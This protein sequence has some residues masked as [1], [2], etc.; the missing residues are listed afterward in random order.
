MYSKKHFKIILTLTIY[1]NFLFLFPKLYGQSGVQ[2]TTIPGTNS[3][4][5]NSG[6]S[7]FYFYHNG[8]LCY[9]YQV[10]PGTTTNGGSLNVLRAYANNETSF[11]PSNFGG[12]RAYLNGAERYP[13][14]PGILFT[15]LNYQILLNDTVQVYWQMIYN[16]DY[17]KY[18]YKFK[19]VGRTLVFRVEIDNEFTNKIREFD[20]D[21]SE[22]CQNPEAIS[23]PYLNLFYI[24]YSN[25]I[26]TSFFTDWE[27]SNASQIVPKDPNY[28][29]NPNYSVRYSQTVIYNEKTNKIR[30][31]MIE[32]FYLTTSSDIEDVFPN[33]PNPVSQYKEEMANWIVWDYRERFNYLSN[34]TNTGEMDK[35][36]NS[37]IRNIWLQIHNW[38]AYHGSGASYDSSGY[39]DGLPCTLPANIIYGG[40]SILN[41]VINKARF[42]YGYRVGLHENYV[43][44]YTFEDHNCVYNPSHVA[45][46]SNGE[47]VKAFVNKYSY[48][49]NIIQSYLLKP[50][51]ASTY[52]NEW[53]NKIQLDH[54]NLNGCYLDVHSASNYVDYDALV[55]NAGMF[56][57]TMKNYRSLYSIIRTNHH[58]PVQGEGGHQIL[59]QGYA[60]DIEARLN[61]PHQ[62]WLG[63]NL[64][65]LVDF[66]M[67]KLREK[68]F[69][70]GVGWYPL[71][72]YNTDTIS[73]PPVTRDIVLSYIATELA[74]GHGGYLPASNLTSSWRNNNH[75]MNDL[76]EFAK[77]EYNHVF[78][79][80]KDYAN[81]TPVQIFYNDNGNLI[82]AS[83][84]IKK[85]PVNYKN[86]ESLD[87]MGQVKI[88]YDN[89]MIVCVNR[90][91]NRSWNVNIGIPNGWFN[92]H[93]DTALDTG[94]SQTTSFNLPP[95]NGWVVYDPLKNPLSVS[96]SGPS[97]LNKGQNGTWTANV[98]AGTAPYIYKWYFFPYCDEEPSTK[99]YI[100][101]GSP[102]P[103][104]PSCGKW[105]GPYQSGP[106]YSH[107]D[108]YDF[109]LKCVVT[110]AN[111]QT[112]TGI[113]YV[114][115]SD[116][117]L[118]KP[119]SDNEFASIEKIPEKFSLNQNYPNPFNPS[120]QIN[121][122]LPSAAKVN[123]KVYDLLGREVTELVNEHKETGFYT[124][125]FN[126][127]NLSSGIYL[128][129]IIAQNGERILFTESK[130]MI[131]LK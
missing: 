19:I 38:Q 94:I 60:D 44:Y 121:Y 35:I 119:N 65:I 109:N 26:F 17:I 54:Q 15:L 120:T 80:Q 67:K 30:N 7:T 129:R 46:Q 72:Y 42:N 126:A 125:N 2:P 90:H 12:I 93:T 53:T 87:F 51:L 81:A 25:N 63:K 11:L 18:K 85:Y 75:S 107:K 106:Q 102:T 48:Y 16:G 116:N 66:D 58:G 40:P 112:A 114:S 117:G 21:R 36:Y 29:Y 34:D 9:T 123:I 84:Y 83:E 28:R 49:P 62:V 71:F 127:S 108:Y 68:T 96:I 22:E 56:R 23:I 118:Q 50:S 104:R 20:L 128:Y 79:V 100:S 55:P 3:I 52:V 69:V 31:R 124:V 113:K 6:T 95:E 5:F 27:I 111:G 8:N 4:S 24:L 88:I 64:P 43:D 1:V 61:T 32:T 37:G 122:A 131:L 82:S 91:P 76:I 103:L 78:S 73:I 89:G 39:D 130:R 57:E 70:H 74:Y 115:V 47:K 10:L 105:Y 101:D 33:I 97:H 110:D 13:W 98:T 14:D 59:Y 86:I 41:L 99:P 92:Y 45:L 77:L